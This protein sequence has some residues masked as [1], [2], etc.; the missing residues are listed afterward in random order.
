MKPISFKESNTIFA[1]NQPPY[2][3]LPAYQDDE[4]GGRII[5]CWKVSIKER[6]K[7]LFTGKL[8][9]EVLNFKQLPQPISMMVN[10]PWG[11]S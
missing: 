5:H 6:I 9:V 2:L 11:K 7:I 10:N 1:E 4:S 8:W 3:P